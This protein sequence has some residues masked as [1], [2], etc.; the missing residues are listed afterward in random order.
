MR[1]AYQPWSRRTFLSAAVAGPFVAAHGR[2]QRTQPDFVFTQYHNQT[3]DSSLHRRLFEMWAAIRNESGGRIETQVFAENNKHPG[4]DPAVLQMLVSGEVQFF[5]LMGGIL[6]N[7]VPVLNVQQVPFAFRTATAAHRTMDGPLGAYLRE[8]LATKG[9]VGFPLGAFDN[10]MRQVGGRTRP[11]RTPADLT[12]LR[13]RVPDGRM[14]EDTFR[15]LGAEPVTV[16]SS[17]IYEALRSGKVDAQENPLAYMHSFRHYEVMKYVSMTNHMW[18][19]FNLIANQAAW[20]CL[21]QDLQSLIERHVGRAVRLQRQDQERANTE[22]RTQLA[23]YG[24]AFNDVDE[25]AFRAKLTGVYAAWKAIL[26]PKC[27]SLLEAEVGKLA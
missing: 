25:V 24:L 9:I 2:A 17:G 18:S 12:G 20:R 6:G 26:G 4:S 19:G 10:G 15:A 11:V 27:W 7:V 16:N 8:E 5:T 1:H 21:P 23:T 14:F 3:A 22:A 13:M